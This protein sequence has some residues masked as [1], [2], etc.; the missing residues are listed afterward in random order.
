LLGGAAANYPGLLGDLTQ[1]D[2]FRVLTTE[3]RMS[4][5]IPTIWR[6]YLSPSSAS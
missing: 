2:A 1:F 5:A 6:H 3:R 4:G